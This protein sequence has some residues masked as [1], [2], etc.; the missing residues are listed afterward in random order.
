MN[1]R[2]LPLSLMLAM[3]SVCFLQTFAGGQYTIVPPTAAAQ[4]LDSD[5]RLVLEAGGHSAIIRESLFTADGREL[6]SVS[7]D[8][9]MRVWSVSP[10]GR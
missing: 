4:T 5:P 7:D 9:T 2:K 3:V 8:K 1:P 6:V 10:D